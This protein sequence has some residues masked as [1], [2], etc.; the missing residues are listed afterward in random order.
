MAAALPAAA[1]LLVTLLS[2]FQR[3]SES[4]RKDR[5]PSTALRP[6]SADTDVPETENNS[7]ITHDTRS[8]IYPEPLQLDF[9]SPVF[10]RQSNGTVYKKDI[11][12]MLEDLN[13]REQE[14]ISD[15]QLLANVIDAYRSIFREN[16]IAGENREVI[17][18][19]SGKNPYQLIFISSDHPAL[20]GGEL[21]DRWGSPFR[22]HPVSGARMEFS[23]AGPDGRFGT[24]DDITLGKEDLIA[25]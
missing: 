15:L 1:L 13:S 24:I 22:F 8:N 12:T 21:V 25:E 14:A 23:S 2:M 3:D 4:S 9:G 16:P 17:E 5:L 18:A 6:P 11:M 20:E 19:L 10:E 7:E